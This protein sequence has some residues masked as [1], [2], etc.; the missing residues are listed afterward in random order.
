M[1]VVDVDRITSID[2]SGA[3]DSRGRMKEIAKLLG[4]DAE[5]TEEQ[6]LEAL[7]GRLDLSAVAKALDLKEDATEDEILEAI[8]SAR[9][10]ADAGEDSLED[11]A[12][13]EGKRVVDADEYDDLRA[14]AKAGRE[15]A[16]K[17]HQRE[18]DDAFD[19]A[20]N[21]PKGARVDAKPETRE[22]YQKLYDKA[23]E[24]TVEML[25]NL[26]RL[27]NGSPTG[28]G[29]GTGSGGEAPDNVD[30]DRFELNERV[31]ERMRK[32]DCSYEEALRKVRAEDGEV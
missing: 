4:L 30:E 6:I 8:K 11:R 12:K 3:S 17:L 1:T 31:E 10:G 2:V 9:E 27:V 15:A 32:D 23:P 16:D 26:P 5:A 7:K 25:D 29:G 22:R 20:L 19:R 21:D 13:A 14:D 28:Q 24:E 18:F